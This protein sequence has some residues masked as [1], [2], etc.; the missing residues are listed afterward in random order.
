MAERMQA[1]RR[2]F[3]VEDLKTVSLESGFTGTVVVQARQTLV[4]T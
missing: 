2:D 1:I 4:E 3:L